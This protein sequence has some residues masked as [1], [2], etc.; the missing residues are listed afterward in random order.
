MMKKNLTSALIYSF[1]LILFLF[2]GIKC[3]Q[4]TLR[5][6]ED[7]LQGLLIIITSIV[8]TLV[9]IYFVLSKIYSKKKPPLES[10]LKNQELFALKKAEKYRREFLGNVSHEL[11]TPVFNIQGYIETLLGGA[12]YDKEVNKK[13]LKRTSKSVDRLIYIIQDLETISR[14]DS[15]RIDLDKTDW[16]LGQLVDEVI[17]QFEIKS[18]KKNIKLINK[19]NS[20]D[21][22]VF[23]DKDKIAQVLYN[24][25]SN[26]IKYGKHGGITTVSC[27]QGKEGCFVNVKDDGIG[28][29]NKNI[30]RLFERFYR[31]DKSRSR[32]QGGTG[33]GLAIV[34]HIVEA[35]DQVIIVK[36]ELGQG[37]KFSFSIS[38]KKS[39]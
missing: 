22:I 39:L 11:K 32:D 4:G 8:L 38:E 28:I 16:H 19:K 15:D 27:H 37:T 25:V 24:L 30:K 6:D 13:Y 12:L 2:F 1:L 17:E 29:A 35:H 18:N 5:I 26:S 10:S 7:Q 21:L 36:S 20:T 14:L 34:K 23:A 31:V 33:L 3:F 9:V